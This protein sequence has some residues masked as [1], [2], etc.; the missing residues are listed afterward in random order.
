MI[1]DYRERIKLNRV[2]QTMDDLHDR[3][4]DIYEHWVE[5]DFPEMKEAIKKQIIE[6]KKLLHGLQEET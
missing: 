6:L 5:D 3:N 2:N 4:N 1:P